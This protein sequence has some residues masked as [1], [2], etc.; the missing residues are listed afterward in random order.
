VIELG[1]WLQTTPLSLGIQTN[2]WITPLLQSIHIVAIAVVYW[3]VSMIALRVLNRMRR[4]EPFAETY[5]RF[6]P[7]MWAGLVV[8]AA[9][10]T[11]LTIGEPVR[12][13]SAVSF[14]MKM[15]LIV[16]GCL[17][18]VSF[19]GVLAASR[20]TGEFSTAARAAAVTTI[21]IWTFIIFLGRA[22]AYDAEVWPIAASANLSTVQE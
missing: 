11:L 8:L 19:R 14:W 6:A 4:D 17:A 7:W 3:S 12:Q 21:V 13:F 16:V 5:Q 9:T 1:Q 22:I 2:L 10:G 15:S 18:V 20:R